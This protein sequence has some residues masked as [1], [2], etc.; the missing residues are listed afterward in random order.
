LT[1]LSKTERNFIL[2]K[3]ESTVEL[4]FSRIENKSIDNLIDTINNLIS[5]LKP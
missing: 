3:G 2:K 4:E 1:D 5:K